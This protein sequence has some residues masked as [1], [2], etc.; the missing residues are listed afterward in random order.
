MLSTFCQLTVIPCACAFGAK[1]A[2][3]PS[4]TGWSMLGQMVTVE[5]DT[6]PEG[7]PPP[8]PPLEPLLRHAVVIAM[9]TPPT[10]N[11]LYREGPR[12]GAP[13]SLC[14]SMIPFERA[15]PVA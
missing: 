12:I 1:P 9:V 3:R 5:P 6:C 15:P 7:V 2:L 8:P 14:G 4:M 13:S 10:A 11:V